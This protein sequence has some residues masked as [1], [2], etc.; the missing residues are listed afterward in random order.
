MNRR[1]WL[2][3]VLGASAVL[4]CPSFAQQGRVWRV[5]FLAA[6]SRSSPSQPDI[7]YDA[8]VQAMRD[9]GYVES[10]NLVI[11]WRFADGN[12]GRFPALASELATAKVDV[13][14]TYVG[15]GTRA[16][17]RATSTIPIV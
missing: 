15:A 2:L 14:V 16:L 5:G 11:E 12:Y 6:R 9:L 17:Q 10:K 7:Y 3:I 4:P 8:F 13:L 1:R